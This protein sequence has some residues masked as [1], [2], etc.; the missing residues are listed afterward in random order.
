MSPVTASRPSGACDLYRVLHRITPVLWRNVVTESG[1]SASRGVADGARGAWN[2]ARRRGDGHSRYV[3]RTMSQHVPP[4][5]SAGR[6][7]ASRVLPVALLTAVVIVGL[8]GA[9]VG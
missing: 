8:R 4:G 9:A 2:R 5:G 1:K 7:V 6:A 3:V